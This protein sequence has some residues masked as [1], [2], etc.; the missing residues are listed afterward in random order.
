MRG[1][2]A[3]AVVSDASSI[4]AEQDLTGYSFAMYQQEFSKTDVARRSVFEN[5]L[6]LIKLHN[7]NP[8]KTWFAGVNQFTDMTNDEFRAMTAGRKEKIFDG[9]AQIHKLTA[10]AHDVPAS[11]DWRDSGKVSPAKDQGGCGSCWAFS[12]A[13]SFE[14]HLAIQTNSTVQTLS[15][16][17]IVSCA[18][19]PDQCGG[20]GGCEGSTQPLAFQYTKTAGLTTEANYPYAGSDGTCQTSKIDPVAYNAGY[21]LLPPNDYTALMDA[22]GNVGPVSISIAAGGS[23]FQ[24]Y[25][26]G[27]M[28]NCNDFVMDHAVQLVGYGTDDD[29]DYWLVRN[30][31]GNW[32]ENGYIRMQRYGE[33]KEPCGVDSKPQDGEACKGDTSPRTYCGECGILSASSYPTD[34]TTVQPAPSPPPPTPEPAP[35]PPTPPPTTP[36]PTPAGCVDSEDSGY[37]DY[38][39]SS[40]SC[41]L[42]GYNCIASCGCCDDA[43]SCGSGEAQLLI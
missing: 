30:S 31:W 37:C 32:G 40:S 23:N 4:V 25:S 22:V 27:V 15:P 21:S 13:E 24:F 18:P 8:S 39:V 41:G 34:F 14:S 11:R 17:Q 26:G 5:N 36:A 33:G 19:N 43:S 35:S 42:I 7:S 12:A 6:N 20:T 9:E 2:F 10:R 3:L 1:L 16:Q 29:K 28:S 38:V